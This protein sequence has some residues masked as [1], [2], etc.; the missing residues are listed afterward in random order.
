MA[1]CVTVSMSNQWTCLQDI[2]V[3]QDIMLEC[4]SLN[5]CTQYVR[6]YWIHIVTVIQETNLM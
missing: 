3:G 1:I 6:I 4:D 2:K 5:V